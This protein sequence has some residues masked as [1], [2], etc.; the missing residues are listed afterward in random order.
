MV[1]AC[2]ASLLALSSAVCIALGDILQQRAA[3]RFNSQPLGYLDLLARLVRDRQWR[4]G[5]V[6]LAASIG[7]Q[8]AALSQYSVLLVQVMLVPS[9]LFALV[10]NARW[11]RRPMSASEWT[12]AG[13]LTAAVIAIVTVGNP[14]P[15]LATAPG[16]TW[17]AVALAFGPLLLACVAFAQRRHGALSAVLLAFVAGSLWGVFAVLAKQVTG[18]LGDGLWEVARAPE[19]YGCLL[20]M[21]G[22]LVLGQAAFRA[23]PL[24]ASMPALEVSQPV[25]AAA[26][27]VLVLGETINTGHLALLLL[28]AATLVMVTA[29]IKLARVEAAEAS[30]GPDRG[31]VPQGPPTGAPGRSGT[32]QRATA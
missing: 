18:R 4:W 10:I 24:T 13:L 3:Y 21:A 15:G 19:L 29:I 23:G 22:G 28:A 14:R 1:K 31:R 6:L 9:V 26:L 7:L 32:Q 12:W 2:I 11:N 30:E 20:A 27:G 17:V 8:A 16:P 25:V 5:A